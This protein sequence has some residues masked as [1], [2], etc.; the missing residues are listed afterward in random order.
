ML[1][2][3]AKLLHE[4]TKSGKLAGAVLRVDR[5]GQTVHLS[6]HGVT[7]FDQPEAVTN[8]TWFDL[9][10]MTKI[11]GTIPAIM[12]LVQN[13]AMFLDDPMGKYLPE[14]KTPLSEVP[15]KYYLSH[16]SGVVAWRPYYNQIA[17]NDLNTKTARE[18]IK[19]LHLAE[20][21]AYEP[22]SEQRYSDVGFALL[23]FAVEEVTGKKLENYVLN[24]I[25][26]KI[27][28]KNLAY[29]QIKPMQKITIAATESCPWREKVMQ[30]EVH[31][32]NTWAAGGCLGQ[33]GLFGT[34]E[35][36]AEVMEE[37]RLAGKDQGKVFT[38]ETLVSFMHK[39]QHNEKETYRLGFDSP[40]LFGSSTGRFMGPNTFGHLGFTG[41]SAWCDP[42]RALTIVL[43]TNRVHPT[44]GNNILKR[45]RPLIHNAVIGELEE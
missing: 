28:P 35:G 40:S 4:A 1:K 37:F 42:D 27:T 8:E 29:L 13:R 11:I 12:L 23:G 41:C 16:H 30:G 21:P 45:L 43:L 15:L 5:A 3:A 19:Q 36:V 6:S 22:G 44:R 25:L 2:A 18:K 14:L 20:R 10:S 38:N 9:A 26:K 39:E 24:N 7:R 17:W 34:A 33:A 31:D 32:E